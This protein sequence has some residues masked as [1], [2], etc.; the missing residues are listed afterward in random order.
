MSEHDSAAPSAPVP[1]LLLFQPDHPALEAV[2]S[3]AAQR[4]TPLI[5]RGAEGFEP[6]D[7]LPQDWLLAVTD[8][9][10]PALLEA[11]SARRATVA[12]LPAAGS[13][14]PRLFA[15]PKT[16]DAQ[17]ALAFEGERMA[18]DITRCNGELVLTTVAIG[19]VPFLDQRGR[20]YLRMQRSRWRR[21]LL[22]LNLFWGAA[23]SLFSIRPSAVKLHIGDEDKPRR[24]AVTGVVVM[25]N[26]VD[27]LS[28]ALMGERLSARDAR[29]S[30]LLLAPASVAAYL[31]VLLRSAFGGSTLPRALSFLKTRRMAIESEQPLAY[32]I[33]GRR[34]S[35]ARIEFEVSPKA[36][37]IRP[38]PGFVDD[39]PVSAEA[40]DTLRLRT[41]PENELRLAS[42]REGLPLFTHALEDDFKDLFLLLRDNARLTPDYVILMIAAT[43]IAGLGL[44]LDSAAVIIGAMVLAP[45]MAPIISLAMG[46]LRRDSGLLQ[47]SMRAIGVGIA[48]ALTAAATLAWLLPHQPITSEIEGRLHPSLLDL[49]VAVVSGIA[50]A[51]A[52]ARENV[53]KSLPGVAIAVALVPPLAVSGIGIGWGE[54]RVFGGAMLL[55]LTNLVGISAAAALTFLVLGYAPIKTAARGLRIMAVAIALLALPLYVSLD[56][57]VEV[58]RLE[59]QL[60]GVV[61][62]GELQALHLNE[63]QVRLEPD[64]VVVRAVLSAPG[65]PGEAQMDRIKAAL[66]AELQRP[67]RLELDVRLVR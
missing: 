35:A 22:A 23:R 29:L 31:A 27:K 37:H 38:G 24:T 8:D 56:R 26:D 55:F 19:D 12:F 63:P 7:D 6:A 50:G 52:H 10:L 46:V 54:A 34:R 43:L 21:S 41:L 39:H 17:V 4:G 62:E 64:L 15:L 44:V 11:A 18:I 45:L 67:V 57:L 49:G 48:L 58:W 20:A 2:R 51:Y 5:E 14:L 32:R 1:V 3:A 59:T 9:A 65:L 28:S 33:D 60:R 53:M 36:L 42:I 61:L 13:V 40:R 16:V 66:E 47:D 25:E 30:A